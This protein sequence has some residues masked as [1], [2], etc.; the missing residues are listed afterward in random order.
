MRWGSSARWHSAAADAHARLGLRQPDDPD[1]S[2]FHV[3]L[4]GYETTFRTFSNHVVLDQPLGGD[5]AADAAAV[6]EAL[7]RGRTFTIID[8][9]ATGGGLEFT[10]QESGRGVAGMGESTPLVANLTLRARVSAP[11]GAR[12]RIM[13]NGI[14][15]NETS[16]ADLTVPA[17]AGVYRV[18]VHVPGAPGTPAIPWLLSNA[19]YVGLARRPDSGD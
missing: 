6:L 13:R 4:P 9:L 14:P 5:A 16:E 12:L 10:A 7:S 19:I 8:G 2:A 15:V 17:E 18:E 3:P 1:R 11:S